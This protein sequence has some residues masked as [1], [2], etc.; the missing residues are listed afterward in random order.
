MRNLAEASLAFIFAVL[1]LLRRREPLLI[2]GLI[3]IQINILSTILE[4]TCTHLS[5]YYIQASYLAK[6]ARALKYVRSKDNAHL[7]S[8]YAVSPGNSPSNNKHLINGQD[9]L[10]NKNG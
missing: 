4:L 8:L 10:S 3:R 5:S 1:K 2:T 6:R 9:F 7:C